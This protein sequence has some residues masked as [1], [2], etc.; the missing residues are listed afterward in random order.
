MT[1]HKDDGFATDR[2]RRWWFANLED[3]SQPHMS[4]AKAAVG[5]MMVETHRAYAHGHTDVWQETRPEAP[6]V[7]FWY[8][9]R[10]LVKES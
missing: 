10:R 5:A 8:V 3:K 1:D 6:T 2:Q 7:P 4:R 9:I